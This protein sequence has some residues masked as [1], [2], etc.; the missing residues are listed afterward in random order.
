MN[1]RSRKYL[2][3]IIVLILLLIVSLRI[4]GTHNMTGDVQIKKVQNSLYVP[5]YTTTDYINCSACR[6]QL[7]VLN[8]LKKGG[9]VPTEDDWKKIKEVESKKYEQSVYKSKLRAEPLVLGRM[10]YE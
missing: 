8:Y 10:I 4:F 5:R 2:I 7:L 9:R 3:A 1:R 6:H